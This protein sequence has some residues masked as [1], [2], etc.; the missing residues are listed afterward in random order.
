MH[1]DD[2]VR[3]WFREVVLPRREVWVAA[4]RDDVIGFLV[5]DDDWIDQLY[6]DPDRT[7]RGVGSGLMAAAKQQR[8]A[9]LRL[10]TFES[11][12]RARQFYER[13]GFVATGFTTGDNEEGAPDVRYEWSPTTVP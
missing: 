3:A 12:D 13:H 7:G 11:N 4:E 5:L 1:T 6:V 9:A 10:W 2:E 8:P